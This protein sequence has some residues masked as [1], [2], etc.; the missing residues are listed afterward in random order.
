MVKR[1]RLTH[2]FKNIAAKTH[3]QQYAKQK[4]IGAF[5]VDG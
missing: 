1:A 5:W 4:I 2:A 3:A